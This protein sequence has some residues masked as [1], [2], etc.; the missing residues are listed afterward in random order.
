[1]YAGILGNGMN[2]LSKTAFA[3]KFDLGWVVALDVEENRI[4]EDFTDRDSG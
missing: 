1:M 3:E 2:I 4:K